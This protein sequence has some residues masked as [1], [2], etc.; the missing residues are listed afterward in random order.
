[1]TGQTPTIHNSSNSYAAKTPREKMLFALSPSLFSLC[2][3]VT[4][5]QTAKRLLADD[6]TTVFASMQNKENQL[7]TCF[8]CTAEDKEAGLWLVVAVVR[9]PCWTASYKAIHHAP[10][11]WQWTKNN[12]E[13]DNYGNV[14]QWDLTVSI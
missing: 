3:S 4:A 10:A 11:V 5:V 14:A 13:V 1:M 2:P 9:W 12:M 7:K 8:K 6:V